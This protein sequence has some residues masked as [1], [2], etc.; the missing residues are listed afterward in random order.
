VQLTA[1]VEP[2][3]ATIKTITWSSSDTAK[4]T[5][6]TDGL[7]TAVASGEAT[8]TATTTDGAK[9]AICVITVLGAGDTGLA[10]GF[11]GFTE[12]A[13]DLTKS[14]AYDLSRNGSGSITVS[15]LNTVTS[16]QW[17]V[18]GQNTFSSAST[19]T[20]YAY[21]Y[22]VGEHKLTAVFE[23]NDVPYSKEVSFRVVE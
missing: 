10:I 3:N 5:V 18:D 16:V 9:T 11:G 22:S 15:V 8:I 1:T 12:S 23:Q 2:A 6:S 20:I 21:N 19:V 14:S 7:V 17:Y 4:A 13:I